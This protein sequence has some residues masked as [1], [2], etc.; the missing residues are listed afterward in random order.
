MLNIFQN[1]F[2]INWKKKHSKFEINVN[3]ELINY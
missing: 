2:N 3:I 1:T